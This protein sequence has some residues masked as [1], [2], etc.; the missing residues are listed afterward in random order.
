M[1]PSP[2]GAGVLGPVL[3]TLAS[4][5]GKFQLHAKGALR[6]RERLKAKHLRP[7]VDDKTAGAEAEMM[8]D[9]RLLR[10]FRRSVS[11]RSISE[12]GEYR[13]SQDDDGQDELEQGSLKKSANSEPNMRRQ[14]HSGGR[15]GAALKGVQDVWR[16]EISNRLERPE[17]VIRQCLK[18]PSSPMK[19][20]LRLVAGACSIPHPEKA[21]S[22]GADSYF[23]APSGA[24]VG[25]ADGVGEWE[26]RFKC[27][28]RAFA[29]ELMEGCLRVTEEEAAAGLGNSNLDPGDVA[30]RALAEGHVSARAFGSAT[31]LSVWLGQGKGKLGVANLG[32]SALMQLRR[33]RAGPLL[34]MRCRSRTREQQHSFNCPYQLCC[35]PSEEDFP[36]LLA[37]GK[38]TLVKVLQKNINPQQD[39]PE[40]SD[41]YVFPVQE[42]DLLVLGTDG[43]FDNLHDDEICQLTN[44]ALSPFEAGE[45]F[46]SGLAGLVPGPGAPSTPPTRLAEAL[47]MAAF[48]RSK[49]LQA[50]TPFSVHAQKAGFYR[51]G[52]KMDDITCVCA[53]VVRTDENKA[54]DEP[55]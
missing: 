27:N 6:F 15:G 41:T 32:D 31:A 20:G 43:V 40:H 25:V 34:S 13:P 8:E 44:Q 9:E 12:C 47:A 36:Q 33:Q 50:K 3:Q 17:V 16:S 24:G 30:L 28:P 55:C 52:G 10:E 37:E 21:S 45:F 51:I 19:S 49:D 4:Q 1:S 54:N 46:S 22:G 23:I 29:D 48:H 14:R 38:H 26:W 35:M 18:A 7:E 5:P 2:D 39:M 42:G 53:W 11:G